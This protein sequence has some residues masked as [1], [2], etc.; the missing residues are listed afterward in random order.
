MDASLCSLYVPGGFDGEAGSEVSMSHSLSPGL[1]AV[2]TLVGGKAA[3]G[4]ARARARCEPGLLCS[5]V[6]TTLL[7]IV[8]FPNVEQKP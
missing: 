6:T 3:E 8:V 2:V 1:L 4:R 5:G 7:G